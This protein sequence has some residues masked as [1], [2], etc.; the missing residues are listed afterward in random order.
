MCG[1][2]WWAMAVSADGHAEASPWSEKKCRTEA[3]WLMTELHGKTADPEKAKNTMNQMR[4]RGC[5]PPEALIKEICF[6]RQ[7]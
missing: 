1:T 5:R 7:V 3:E 4:Y 6:V 2:V